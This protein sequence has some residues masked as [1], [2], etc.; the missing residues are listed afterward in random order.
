MAQQ[1]MTPGKSEIRRRQVDISDFPPYKGPMPVR[2]LL[3]PFTSFGWPKGR[4][5]QDL[6]EWLRSTSVSVWSP[7]EYNSLRDAY[8]YVR[9][10]PQWDGAIVEIFEGDSDQVT[11]INS[12]DPIDGDGIAFQGPY[13]IVTKE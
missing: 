2:V 1:N 8:A 4:E 13:I 11:F 6:L 7:D 10:Q 5:L 9:G 3:F 12:P